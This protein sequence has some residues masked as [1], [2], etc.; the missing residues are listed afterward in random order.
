MTCSVSIRTGMNYLWAAAENLHYSL[1]GH[2]N[3]LYRYGYHRG[4][5]AHARER[6]SLLYS[7]IGR[8]R[9]SVWS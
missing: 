4:G 2:S 5:T 8:K 1:T 9:F 7:E 6:P 3:I